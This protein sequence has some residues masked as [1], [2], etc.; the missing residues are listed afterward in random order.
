MALAVLPAHAQAGKPWE[1]FVSNSESSSALKIL[2]IGHSK[3]YINNM[4]KMFAY[5]VQQKAGGQPLK[6]YSVFGDAYT[7]E[8]HLRQK[9]ALK[10]IR[11]Q[12]PWDYVVL[13]ERSGYPEDAKQIYDRS[14]RVFAPEIKKIGAHLVLVENYVEPRFYA[15]SHGVMQFFQNRYKCYLLPVGSAWNLIRSKHPQIQILQPDGH[16]P[17]TKG[18]YLMSCVCYAYF[19]G[20]NPCDLPPELYSIDDNNNTTNIFSNPEEARTL[21]KAAW[22][23]VSAARRG[24]Q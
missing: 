4:P 1:E 9:L 11:E 6:L 21:Q 22:E 3:L 18:T 13:I 2:F 20:K 5:F 12:G 24:V 15:E 23:A 7:L 19:L 14:L 17:G 10:A 8:E 16:H